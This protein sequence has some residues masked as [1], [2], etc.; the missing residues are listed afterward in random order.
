M[1]AIEEADC[2][3]FEAWLD[4]R[5]D[6]ADRRRL[7]ALWQRD[8]AAF[9]LQARIA[10]ALRPGDSTTL[11]QQLTETIASDPQATWRRLHRR[12]PRHRQPRWSWILA[13]LLLLGCSIAGA[14]FLH[15]ATAPTDRVEAAK[16]YVFL[17]GERLRD[18]VDRRFATGTELQGWRGSS[19]TVQLADDSLLLLHGGA[20]QRSGPSNYRLRE[21]SLSAAIRPRSTRPLRI[22]TPH[23][24]CAIVGTRFRLQSDAS[25]TSLH[26]REGRVR[27]GDRMVQ[28]PAN[29]WIA[30]GEVTPIVQ[31]WDPRRRWLPFAAERYA[32]GQPV[33]TPDGDLAAD[34]QE[35]EQLGLDQAVLVYNGASA[36]S[37]AQ[38]HCEPQNGVSWLGISHP[39]LF[40]DR[41]ELRWRFR[42]LR[43]KQRSGSYSLSLPQSYD[44]PPLIPTSTERDI[45]DEA[46]HQ[47][48]VL[49][50][51]VGL[52]V[53]GAAICEARVW[54]DGELMLHA[55]SVAPS[56]LPVIE[57]VAYQTPVE[58]RDL[59][60]RYGTR[61]AP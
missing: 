36:A 7:A 35:A 18:P 43:P 52:D 44:E 21:G 57:L 20:L 26:L 5:A 55:W 31:P 9:S 25:G 54:L 12:L 17:D 38:L 46:W 6:A 34:W 61:P 47:V 8:P 59:T 40:A 37:A 42:L 32:A 29:A 53:T 33:L 51:Q 14:L 60:V 28:A 4:G 49:G 24:S 50:C 3:A 45:D 56:P 58:L 41:L 13:A 11:A 2:L 16:G 22:D 1:T 27:F 48:R 23:G 30:A 10:T 15:P 39:R 19:A